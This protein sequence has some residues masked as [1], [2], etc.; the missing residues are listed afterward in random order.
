M[1][2]ESVKLSV[3]QISRIERGFGETTLENLAI[4]ADFYDMSLTELL[5]I[6]PKSDVQIAKRKSYV[7]TLSNRQTT[8]RYS[9]PFQKSAKVQ[10]FEIP[11]RALKNIKIIEGKNYDLCLIKGKITVSIRDDMERMEEGEILS[12]K[13]NGT[14]E[15]LNTSSQS[16]CILLFGY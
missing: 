15:V 3:H 1:L 2:S 16:A 13:G 4:L 6:S 12:T 8:T 14:L 7:E 11:L 5:K 9:R 10:F